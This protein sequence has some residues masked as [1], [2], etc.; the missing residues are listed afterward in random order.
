MRKTA[1][2]RPAYVAFEGLASSD[3]R[4]MAGVLAKHVGH[5]MD[6]PLLE[7][8]LDMLVG[9]E[10]YETISWQ[11][12]T[13]AAGE[14][15]LTIRGRPR[16]YAPPFLMLGF[17]LENTASDAFKVSASARYLQ[18]DVAGSG[19]ELRV[20]GT[21]GSDA[22][23]AAEL[24]RPIGRGFFASP[25]ALFSDHAFHEI[26]DDRV[27]ATYGRRTKRVGLDLGL[28]LGRLSDIRIGASAGTVDASVVIGDP[29][30]PE[31]SGNE[32]LARAAWRY[33]SQDSPVVPG[34][35]I[36]AATSLRHTL[37]GPEGE[38]SGQG[39]RGGA[40]LTQL[41]GEAS[42]FWTFSDRNRI[43]A[44]G[45]GGTSFNRQPLRFDQFFLGSPLH[46]GGFG[47]GE[48]FGDHYVLATTGYLR[49]FNHLPSF[50][51]GRVFVGGWIENGA[52]FDDWDSSSWQTQFSAGVMA[53][54]VLGPIMI[55][56]TAG[57][58]RWRTYV[59]VG[60]IF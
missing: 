60:P 1:L 42:A 22:A 45:G 27:V 43:F 47:V 57:S 36:K 46:L 41:D 25:Y 55:G 5:D 21:A 52:A 37:E 15:G 9:L 4:L 39:S 51:G 19:S 6:I 38:A 54:T 26:E 56:T 30:L 34:R 29:G 7:H 48:L 17:T 49:E 31:V 50:L 11:V 2:P 35:G 12:S 58:G 14:T 32:T 10:R 13:K 16:P 3:E 53:D 33:D 20:D 18:F 24:Y 8:D 44:L 28:N 40:G 23:L 59:S